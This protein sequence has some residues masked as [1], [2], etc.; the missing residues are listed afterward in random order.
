MFTLKLNN[1]I[2]L[3]NKSNI[4]DILLVYIFIMNYDK[5]ANTFTSFNSLKFISI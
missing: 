2:Y 1:R 4:L 3:Y 5:I